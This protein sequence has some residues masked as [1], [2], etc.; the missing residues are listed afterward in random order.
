MMYRK[1]SSALFDVANVT[2]RKNHYRIQFWGMT[3]GDVES[4]MKNANLSEKSGQ[5]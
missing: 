5:L 1:N 3:K 4:R 2:V